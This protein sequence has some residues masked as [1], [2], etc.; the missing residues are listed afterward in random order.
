M[1]IKILDCTLRDGGHVN[2]WQF[3][4][5]KISRI[6]ENL[7]RAQVDFIEMGFLRDT[8]YNNDRS[9]FSSIEQAN[10]FLNNK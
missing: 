1:T 7:N 8:D 2:S 3:G 10:K 5:D 4:K 6:L 9:L